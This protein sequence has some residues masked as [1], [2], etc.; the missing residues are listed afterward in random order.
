MIVAAALVWAMAVGADPG[1]APDGPPSPSSLVVS[2]ERTEAR[3]G[4]PFAY[5]IDVRHGPGESYALPGDMDSPPFR[6]VSRGCRRAEDGAEVRTTCTLSLAI[7]ELGPHDVPEVRLAVRTPEGE[8]TLAVP[9]PR[10]TGIGIIDPAA[11]P[12]TLALRDLAPPVPLLVPSFRLLAWAAGALAA[13]LAALLL[14]R[15]RRS[16]ARAALAPPPPEAPA[17]R[18][19]RRLDVLEAKGLPARGAGREH[20]FELSEIVREWVGAV[21]GVSA[22]DLTTAE[23]VE[24]LGRAAPPAVDVEALRR[25]CEE[26]DLVKYARAPADPAECAAATAFARRLG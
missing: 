10:I 4:E 16:R 7:F 3:L 17:A 21:S 20:V 22:L 6:G 9:G 13:V 24:R 11:P 1:K 5:Q 26:A 12:E 14:R 2:A 25:F 8:A 18:L 19:Q 15:A 23:L